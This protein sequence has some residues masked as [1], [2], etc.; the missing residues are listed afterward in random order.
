MRL[1]RSLGQSPHQPTIA[2]ALKVAPTAE[3]ASGAN[4]RLSVIVQLTYRSAGDCVDID[5]I[6]NLKTMSPFLFILASDDL[7]CRFLKSGKFR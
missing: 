5:N 3:C 1:T 6:L 7:R 4:E 2:W